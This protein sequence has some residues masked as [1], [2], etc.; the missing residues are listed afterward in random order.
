MS[1]FSVFTSHV[2]VIWR[3]TR[4]WKPIKNFWTYDVSR[5][6]AEGKTTSVTIYE[7]SKLLWYYCFKLKM[8]NLSKKMINFSYRS[9][10]IRKF[11]LSIL[12]R[13]RKDGRYDK[14]RYKTE[15]SP[16]YCLL[17]LTSNIRYTTLHWR[18]QLLSKKDVNYGFRL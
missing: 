7:D 12:K 2:G 6:I 10:D 5:Q 15:N 17:S 8:V 4:N 11:T 13:Y 16:L 1:Y 18:F 3:S 9:V 14:K